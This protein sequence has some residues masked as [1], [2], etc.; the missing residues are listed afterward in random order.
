M[1]LS[2]LPDRPQARGSLELGVERLNRALDSSTSA[3]PVPGQPPALLLL[4]PPQS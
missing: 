2:A 1:L 4:A 3:D